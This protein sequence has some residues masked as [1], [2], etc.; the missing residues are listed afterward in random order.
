MT[1]PDRQTVVPA[2]KQA[3]PNDWESISREM[4]WDGLMGCWTF[5]RQTL[6]GPCMYG[7]ETDGYIHT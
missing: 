3:F 7:V 6:M 4:Y 1:E 5:W 2:L